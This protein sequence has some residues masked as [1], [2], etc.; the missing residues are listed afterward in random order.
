MA[1]TILTCL[2]GPEVVVGLM[3]LFVV[4]LVVM[5]LVVPGLCASCHCLACLLLLL[6]PLMFLF[7]FLLLL[8]LRL[9]LELPGDSAL[10]CCCSWNRCC[11]CCCCVLSWLWLA[12]LAAGDRRPAVWGGTSK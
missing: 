11:C 1:M 10:V 2:W 6:L 4:G 8:L 9:P 7:L 5:L 3:L 12:V